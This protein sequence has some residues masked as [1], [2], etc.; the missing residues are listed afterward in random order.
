MPEQPTRRNLATAYSTGFFSLSLLQMVA[1]ATP[2]F[3]NHLGLSAALLGVMAGARSLAP[4]VY[5]IHL[6]SVMD[7]VGVRRIMLLLAASGVLLAPLYPILPHPS[8]LIVLQLLLGL[9]AAICWMGAQIAISRSGSGSARYMARF[10]FITIAGSVLGPLLLGFVWDRAGPEGGYGLISLWSV[11]LFLAA[12]AMKPRQPQ[13]SQSLMWRDMIPSPRAYVQAWQILKKPVGAFVIGCTFLRL[14]SFGVVETFYPAYLQQVAHSTLTIGLLVALANLV[15]SPAAFLAEAWVKVTGSERVALLTSIAVSIVAIA[16]T[17]LFES[18][19]ALAVG[20]SVF[21]LGFGMSL[22]LI[23]VLLS[24]GV[25]A[26]EQGLAAGLR[27][28]VNRLAAFIIPV[29]TGIIV[30]F[31]SIEAA[32]YVIGVILLALCIGL[33]FLSRSL[34]A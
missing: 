9:A 18:V 27:G 22:P 17:P 25:P 2:L 23:M 32:F 11:L 19:W 16:A 30:E 21:G 1:L 33:T 7:R 14:A 20:I 10:S 34:K 6:G 13:S 12:L 26:D 24:R 31:S 5:S 15:S 8:I 28:T 3:S 29:M 4:L